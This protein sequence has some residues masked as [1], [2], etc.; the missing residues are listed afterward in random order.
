MGSDKVGVA[1]STTGTTNPVTDKVEKETLPPISNEQLQK[2]VEDRKPIMPTSPIT[3]PNHY[4]NSGNGKLY[5]SVAEAEAAVRT[6]LL[7]IGEDPIRPGLRE[8]PGRVVKALREMT[9]GYQQDPRRILSKVFEQTYDEMVVVR[10]ITFDSIC[11]HHLLHFGGTVDIGYVPSNDGVV[12]LS[13]LARLVDCFARRL[14]IQEHLTT[15]IASTIQEY[16]EPKGVA[17]VVR[18][19]HSCMSCRGVRKSNSEMVTSCM[20]GCF[21]TLPEARQEFLS[22]CSM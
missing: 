4:R 2:E 6:L 19:T 8:T 1:V 18:A 21:R 7:Y 14:Q 20:L 9:E 16:L 13:K 3:P 17:V 15:Q 10:G 5:P 12:G 11:E 22:L